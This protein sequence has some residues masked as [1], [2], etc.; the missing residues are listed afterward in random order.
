MKK[1]FTLIELLV[2]VLVIGIL[3]AVAF[4]Q[5]EKAVVKA[6]VAK[7][8][9][10]FKKI[11]EGREIYLMNGGKQSCQDLGRYMDALGITP[12]RVRCSGQTSDGICENE[13]GWCD[14][15]LYID[16]KTVIQTVTGHARYFYKRSKNQSTNDFQLI[17]LTLN[18][19]YT[20]DE[21][22]GDFFCKP[23]T[24][25]GIEMCRTLASDPVT[26]QCDSTHSDCYRIN[27]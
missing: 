27:L 12:Y 14:S 25:W 22:T 20:S 23:Q 6:K 10:W 18:F 16:D 8:I 3:A 2:V 5:Y 19:G 17:L 15:V 11:K 7:V 9:P 26:V 21:K 1:G 4:P 24:D 13:D